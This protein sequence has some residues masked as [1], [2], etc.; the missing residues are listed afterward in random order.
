MAA[1]PSKLRELLEDPTIVKAGVN[2]RGM[3]LL[4]IARFSSV[5]QFIPG[6][7]KKLYTDHKVK[8]QNLVEL[9]SLSRIADPDLICGGGR[10]LIRLQK[11]VAAYLK[12]NLVKSEVRTG[13]WEYRLSEEQLQCMR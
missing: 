6:D 5:E 13:D 4:S 3:P 8:I 1:F 2:V 7:A 12:H 10:K 11:L 9:S